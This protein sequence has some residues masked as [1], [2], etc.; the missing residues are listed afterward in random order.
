LNVGSARVKRSVAVN[1]FGQRFTLKSD[2]DDAYVQSLAAL[3]DEKMRE[4][5]RAAKTATPHAVAVLAAM[6]LADELA[7]SRA[8]HGRL[9]DEVRRR[10]R[11]LRA[12][13]DEARV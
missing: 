13:L 6:Q 4:V 7:R 5:Q 11:N 12:L 3:V 1:I 10:T 8:R 2:A 9:K